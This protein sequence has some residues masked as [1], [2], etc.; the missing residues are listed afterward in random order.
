MGL[1]DLA[2]IWE[3]LD[4]KSEVK[5]AKEEEEKAVVVG[6]KEASGSGEKAAATA[7]LM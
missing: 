4:G 1:L 6:E 2:L 7:N 5:D 3:F